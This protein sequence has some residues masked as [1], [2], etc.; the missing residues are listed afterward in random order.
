MWVESELGRGSTFYFTLK[1][2]RAQKPSVSSL[3]LDPA[4]L[5]NMPVL[6]IDDNPTNRLI[7][8]ELLRQ[9]GMKPTLAE[10]GKRGIVLLDQ[11]SIAG[12]V[13]PLI[14]LDCHMPDMDGFTF[15]QRIKNDPRFRGAIVMMLTSGGQRGDASRCRQL[16]IAAYLVKPIQESEL[17]AA[18]LTV[19]GH[20]VESFDQESTLVTRH[21]LRRDRENLHIL[22]AEDNPVNQMV[23]VR[24][25]E[26]LGHNVKVANNG[27][28]A[29]AEMEV[30]Q[31]D[32]IL[33][34][35]QMPEM[36]GFETT[37]AIREK[38]VTTGKHIPIIAMTAHA[39]KGDRERCLTAGMDQYVAK[40]IRPA[41]LIEA[42]QQ[43]A[44]GRGPETAQPVP[45][46]DCIDWPA[47]WANLEG[48]HQLLGELARL[49]LEDLP[50]Q[51]KAIHLAAE[52][53]EQH[54][55]EQ[56][57][58]RLKSS[59]GNFAARSAFEAAFHL[60]TVA[61]QGEVAQFPEAVG[62]LES[63]IHR[64]QLALEKWEDTAE[65]SGP[66]V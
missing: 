49:F 19:L 61:R 31:F 18:I 41:E 25:L 48:D 23:A 64:L 24:Q 46:D 6:V 40:P 28:E 34:D 57:A 7:L 60:E 11:A 3:A 4:V 42:I 27:R 50:R 13:F 35:V 66:V 53:A 14:L 21:S 32:L 10:S 15:A 5:R 37:R 63:E 8:A 2:I 38:E 29:L 22:L 52:N 9:W 39:M 16:R 44:G 20:K 51:M 65:A 33:M 30:Q 58:H 12:V 1:F 54:D 62:A 59:V 26:K 56:A 45:H 47:A 55:L 43:L 17:L 36:D